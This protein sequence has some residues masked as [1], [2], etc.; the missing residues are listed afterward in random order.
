MIGRYTVAVDALYFQ[1][2][3]NFANAKLAIISILTPQFQRLRCQ[4]MRKF[5]LPSNI[6]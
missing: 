3:R 6:L 1:R 5:T 4:K 2:Y